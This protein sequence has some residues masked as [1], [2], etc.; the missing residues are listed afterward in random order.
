MASCPDSS[1]EEVL[2]TIAPDVVAT[3]AARWTVPRADGRALPVRVRRSPAW[4]QLSADSP[5]P[6]TYGR[7]D[8]YWLRLNRGLRGSVRTARSLAEQTIHLRADIWCEDEGDVSGGIRRAFLDFDDAAHR[9]AGRAEWSQSTPVMADAEQLS[10]RIEHVCL[11]TG[12]PCRRLSGGGLRVDLETRAGAYA[13]LLQPETSVDGLVVELGELPRGPSA[14]RRAI[15][16]LLLA[17][18]A[19]VRLVKGLIITHDGTDVAMMSA[20]LGDG[21]ATEFERS[22]SALIVACG[23]AAREV[24]ALRSEE[25][26]LRYL[27]VIPQFI[28]PATEE[29]LACP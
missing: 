4:L 8:L 22:V 27:Q 26:A 7:D 20:S 5:A 6:V 17:L 19:T 11:E 25:L 3:G 28:V 13:A 18:S 15:G 2:R 14:S 1:I 9:L 24:E 16:R 12:W 21:S 29:E 10:D 23:I